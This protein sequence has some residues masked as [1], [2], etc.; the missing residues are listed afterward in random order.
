MTHKK[1]I[2]HYKERQEE[3]GHYLEQEKE[4]AIDHYLDQFENFLKENT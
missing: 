3:I 4:E 2:D 1:E